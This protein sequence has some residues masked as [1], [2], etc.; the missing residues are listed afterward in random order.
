M[1]IQFISAITKF[2]HP[3]TCYECE[4]GRRFEGKI[5]YCERCEEAHFICLICLPRYLKDEHDLG[6]PMNKYTTKTK[7]EFK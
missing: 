1:P 6:L 3:H 4:E 5:I 7:R 2:K